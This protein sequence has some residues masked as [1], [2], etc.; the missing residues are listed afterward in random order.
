MKYASGEEVK[1]GD[2]VQFDGDSSGIV[3][4]S[5]DLDEYSIAHP[6]EQWSYLE[7]GVMIEFDILGLVHFPE[8]DPE[9][10]LLSREK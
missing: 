10:L 6:K 5:I 1:T 7:K 2:R 9:L 8:F 4:C 3:V